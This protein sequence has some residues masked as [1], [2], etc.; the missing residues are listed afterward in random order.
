MS[1]RGKNKHYNLHEIERRHFNAAAQH[2]KYNTD[3]E[4]I[5]DAVIAATPGVIEQVGEQLPSGFPA[6]LFDVIAS[7]LRTAADKLTR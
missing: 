1:L 3:M 7:G 6:E 5:L 4:D 2:C